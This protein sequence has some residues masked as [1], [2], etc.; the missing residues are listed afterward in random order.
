MNSTSSSP[1]W[2]ISS[3]PR[4]AD[5]KVTGISNYAV[6]YDNVDVAA[7]TARGIVVG[8]TPCTYRWPTPPVTS[9]TATCL[10]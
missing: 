7:A 2:R 6:G 3:T 9:S 5:A 1:N 10:R 4:L 8:N